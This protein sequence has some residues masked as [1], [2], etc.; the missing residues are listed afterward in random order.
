VLIKICGVTNPEDAQAAV[1]SGADFV[2]M[3][4][5]PKTKRA[6]SDETAK[7]IASTAK[8]A[9]AKPVGVFV[10]EDPA[11]I[12][13]RCKRAGI[14]VAQLHGDGARAGLAA[15]QGSG[16]EVVYVMNA[17]PEGVIQTP[18]PAV[19]P[20]WILVDGMQG[21]S[22]QALDWTKL[23]IPEGASKRGWLLAGGLN[24]GNVGKAISIAR[25]GAVDVSSGV[26]G[27]DGL[28]KDHG[29]VAAFV[30]GAKS[31]H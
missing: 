27:P 22:G 17:T 23:S 20:D 15:L 6:V 14:P 9:G 13:D 8:A 21:G 24:P 18:M 29:K 12:V 11:T 2:G 5:W 28:K 7:A 31:A 26:C 30:E 25:P 3:I 1:Q 16:L 19:K 4:M 10:D